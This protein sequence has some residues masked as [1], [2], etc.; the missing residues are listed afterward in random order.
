M[1]QF[2]LKQTLADIGPGLPTG[3]DPQNG[4]RLN[5]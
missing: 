2:S 4:I 5:D 1:S 3:F